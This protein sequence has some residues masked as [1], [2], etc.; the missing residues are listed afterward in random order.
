M[1]NL[2]LSSAS[3]EPQQFVSYDLRYYR[4][5][6]TFTFSASSANEWRHES[7]V[8]LL[9]EHSNGSTAEREREKKTANAYSDHQA[10][11]LPFETTRICTKTQVKIEWILHQKLQSEVGKKRSKKKRHTMR[12]ATMWCDVMLKGV[13]ASHKLSRDMKMS[14]IAQ[15]DILN[16]YFNW[17][18]QNGCDPSSVCMHLLANSIKYPVL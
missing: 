6:F 9:P 2:R 4:K 11:I 12:M 1:S 5:L 7:M 10:R 17:S 13:L 3:F 18:M 8:L 15:K 16:G 14:L